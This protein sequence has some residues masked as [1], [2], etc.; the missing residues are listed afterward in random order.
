MRRFTGLLLSVNWEFQKTP[1]FYVGNQQGGPIYEVEDPNDS[2]IECRYEDY[3]VGG[4]F[5]TE[6]MNI[7]VLNCLMKNI[8][9]F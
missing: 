7:V 5:E 9:H 6:L 2:V 4:A 1:C 3:R 8:V